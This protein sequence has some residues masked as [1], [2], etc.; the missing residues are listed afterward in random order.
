MRITFDTNS[1]DRAVRPQRY[2]KDALQADYLKIY[3]ALRAGTLHG[4]FSETLITLEGVQIS[5][6]VQ[7]FGSTRFTLQSGPSTLS[8]DGHEIGRFTAVFQQDRKPLHPEHLKRV[9]AAL[10][11]GMRA[12]RAP[13]RFAW[14]RVEDPEGVI[15]EPD[16]SEVQNRSF[17]IARTIEERGVG[18]Q[19]VKLLAEQFASRD[20]VQEPWTDS[21]LRAKDIHENRAVSRAI[22]EWADADTVIAHFAYRNH[23]LCSEDYGKAGERPSIFNP[24]NRAWLHAA[25]GIEFVSLAQLAGMV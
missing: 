10:A 22:A 1:L 25:Y 5:D 4:Y 2:P 23:Y 6:R 18:D 15:F 7:V 20:K 13:P 8:A 19:A 24:T 12:L 3:D 17:D 9:Q 14:A 21:L 16:S 11:L